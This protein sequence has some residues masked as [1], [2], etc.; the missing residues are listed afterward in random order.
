MKTVHRWLAAAAIVAGCAGL[1]PGAGA[2]DKIRLAYGDVPSVESLNML[3]AFE[4]ARARGVEVELTSVKEEDLAAQ[5]VVTG[6]ADVGVGTPYALL[7]KVK[8]PIR[9]FFQLS[10][11]RFY[12]VVNKEYYQSWKDLDG[13]EIAVHS[14]G[15]G[16]EAIMKLMAEKHGIHYSKISYVPGSEVRAG[17][18]LQ[19][20]VKASIVDAANW[21]LI[22]EKAPGKF[23]TLPMEGVNASDETLYANEEF[24]KTHAD[25]VDVLVEE[26]L[27]TW[28]EI[29][30]D[31]K[32]VARLRDEMKLLP[33]LPAELVAEID[34]YYVE[35]TAAHTFPLNGGGPDA[36]KD[37]F[38]F[39]GLA[40]QLSGDPA[41]LKVEDFWDFGPLDRALAKLGRR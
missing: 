4:R 21:R 35:A 1:A 6:E 2:A 7:Q 8:A 32:A 23:M 30:A 34:P 10:T 25:A 22:Q 16:T 33:E 38:A 3:I 41:S 36:A 28:R 17:A 29:D 24:L 5:A 13:Q 26:L 37:D 12:T 19:G 14:R 11:L 27:K 20:T 39:Y 18:L 15:S 31:P 9:M 40:G